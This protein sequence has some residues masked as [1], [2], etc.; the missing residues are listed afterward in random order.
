MN[1]LPKKLIVD[2]NVPKEANLATK[3]D[4]LSDVPVECIRNCIDAILRITKNGGL[5]VDDGGEIFSEY[6]ANLS[7]SGQ[8]GVGDAFAKWV[9]DNQWNPRKVDRVKIT[10]NNGSY[11]EFPVHAG[12]TE[13]DIND[14]KFI[15]TANCHHLK[16]PILQA[17]DSKWWGWNDALIE[18][19][20]K[21][22]FLCPDYV[23]EKFKEKFKP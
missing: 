10:K 15:A 18:S 6:I 17:T 7:L 23:E 8:P 19:G 13:F 11:N 1:N 3:P 12:L 14:R 22:L 9:H 21:V 4:S 2:T 16:P 20:I 5:V